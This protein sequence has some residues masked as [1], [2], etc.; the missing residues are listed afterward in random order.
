MSKLFILLAFFGNWAFSQNIVIEAYGDSLTAGLLDYT[1]V[2]ENNNLATIS[3]ILSDLSMFKLTKDRKFLSPHEKPEFAWPA[4]IAERLASENPTDRFE[5]RNYALSGARSDNLYDEVRSAKVEPQAQGAIGLFF[6]GH[7]D[8]CHKKGPTKEMIEDFTSNYEA[9]L[10][11]WDRVHYG[12]KAFIVSIADIQKLYP[13]LDGQAWYEG[14]KGK[15][16][17]NESWEKL[18]P[19][20]PHFYRKFKEKTLTDYLNPRIQGINMALD[21]LV[22]HFKAHS[23]RNQYYRINIPDE[24]EFKKNFFAVDCYHLSRDGQEFV[25]ENVYRGL[26]WK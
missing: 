10:L 21:S 13:L 2:T 7:N 11:E 20:C 26:S 5:V 12:A 16:R 19:Y 17:C 8:L 22:D 15:Y 23:S 18:F 1:N 3:K 6:I 25:F 9:A 24:A 14:E 4:A